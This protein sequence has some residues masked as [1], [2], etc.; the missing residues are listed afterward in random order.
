MFNSLRFF[1]FFAAMVSFI[2]P[3]F[4][5]ETASFNLVPYPKEIKTTSGQFSFKDPTLELRLS[6]KSRE[7]LEKIITDELQRAGF[8]LPKVVAVDFDKPMLSLAKPDAKLPEPMLPKEAGEGKSDPGE[9]YALSIMPDGIVCHGNADIGL[10]YAVQ[11][12]RQLIRANADAN[13][14]LPCLTIQDWS[15]M[16]YR[17]YQ[18]DWTRGPSPHIKAIFY[19]FDIGVQLKHNMF[20]YYMENQFEFKKHPKL[21]PQDGTLT[22]EEFKQAVEYAAK[23]HLIVLGNQQSFGHYQKILRVPEYAH[24]G[25]KSHDNPLFGVRSPYILSPVVEEVYA[26]L[27]D[28]YS[29]ILPLVPFEMFNVCCDETWDL[30]KSGPSKELADKIGVSGV[31]LKHILR[32]HELLKK[33]NKR[34]MMWGDVLTAKHSSRIDVTKEPDI[35]KQI[36]KDVI[37][38]CWDYEPRPNFDKDIK[39]FS[40]SGYD[41]FVCPGISNWSMM[42]PLFNKSTVNIRNMV[43]D[44]CKYGAMGMLNTGWEDDGESIHGCNWYGIAWGAECSWNA[45]KTEPEDFQK[46]IGPVLFGTK[47]DDFGKAIEL[48]AE[49]QVSPELGGAG[50]RR[51]WERDFLPRESL[52]TVERKARHISKLGTQAIV[53]LKKTKAQ[54]TVNAELLDSFLLGAA[55]MRMIGV[56]MLYGLEAAKWYSEAAALDLSDP[57]QKKKVIMILEQIERHAADVRKA[58]RDIETEFVRIWNTESKP[59]ALDWTTKKYDDYDEYLAEIQEKVSS[60]AKAF[61]E[62]KPEAELPDIGLQNVDGKTFPSRFMQDRLLP[63]AKWLNPASPLRQGIVI[64]AGEV[65]QFALPVELELSVQEQYRNKKVE[66]FHVQSGGQSQQIPAQLDT[67][68][69]R[70]KSTL[71]FLLPELSKDTSTSIHVYFG[72]DETRPLAGAVTTT[73][74]PGDWKTV[75]NDKVRLAIGPEGGHVYRWMLKDRDLLDMTDPGDESYHG[76]SDHGRGERSVKFNLV[77]LNNGPA[78]V[79]YG[80]YRDGEICKT[81]SV[82]AGLPVLDVVMSSPTNYYWNFDAPELFAA[83]GKTPGTLLFSNGTTAPTARRGNTVDL[84]TSGKGS[85]WGIKYNASGIAHGMTTPEEVSDFIIGPGGGMGGV[86]VAGAARRHFVTFAGSLDGSP[87]EQTMNRLKETFNRKRKLH[88]TLHLPENV[89]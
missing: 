28:L 76:F 35:I 54:A 88:V 38:M 8:P 40:D 17:C 12:L 62:N 41:F 58:H 39:P 56:R 49:L 37:M 2:V 72:L 9:G 43:R 23:Q 73:E 64:K 27:D 29:E 75:E 32:V 45:A 34:M 53:H 6:E 33:Y 4:A 44:G 21:N 55:R 80:C 83:D 69:Q 14:N 10:F 51:F 63:D 71:V 61:R 77:L 5:A 24:L 26:F 18:D 46:R 84:Q 30:A 67:G 3:L 74:G 31:Y 47:S 42:L 66:A 60:A 20:T 16:K 87:P 22:Q 78:M 70:G 1:V 85:Y 79:R 11:T 48:L 68:S 50:N 81:L 25:E 36:P 89:R 13:G 57:E 15:S 19:T 59:Y 52:Q 86:G 65:N 82:Y 7:T